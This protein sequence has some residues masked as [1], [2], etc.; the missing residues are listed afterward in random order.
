MADP[1]SHS[2][3]EAVSPPR[4][5][6]HIG[7][8]STFVTLPSQQGATAPC[9]NQDRSQSMNMVNTYE[10]D[11]DPELQELIGKI[12]FT[13]KGGGEEWEGIDVKVDSGSS[14]SLI[15]HAT[16]R[17]LKLKP[18]PLLPHDVFSISSPFNQ[19]T[20][21]KITHYVSLTT[22]CTKLD[23][24]KVDISLSIADGDWEI[25]VGNRFMNK[26]NLWKR[27]GKLLEIEKLGERETLLAL[28][29]YTSKGRRTCI[30]T[31]LILY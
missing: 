18:R 20:A 17:F 14:F 16:V 25:L 2:A 13:F 29:S 24:E 7:S 9:V 8:S 3:A 30:H 12:I 26:H 19:N 27:I 1:Q 22:K 5:E 15:S 28:R 6:S 11:K 21:V 10:F 23:L 31:S 4:G